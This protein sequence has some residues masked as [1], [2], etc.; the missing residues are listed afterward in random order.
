MCSCRRHCRDANCHSTLMHSLRKATGGT[1]CAARPRTSLAP[2]FVA[3]SLATGGCVVPNTA[4]PGRCCAKKPPPR[5]QGCPWPS[6]SVA[7]DG[8][9]HGR[10]WP[11][12]VLQ[13]CRARSRAP[14]AHERRSLCHQR[15]S[16]Q[17]FAGVTWNLISEQTFSSIPDIETGRIKYR[18]TQRLPIFDPSCIS[19]GVHEGTTFVCRPTS[20]KD[21]PGSVQGRGKTG[22]PCCAAREMI[23]LG[24]HR[25]PRETECDG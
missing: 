20:T 11:W 3:H 16:P 1:M 9:G 12:T 21:S 13:S 25:A 22:A 7:K 17:P 23:P 2:G 10:H 6:L 19:G 24:P 15:T 4:R 8:L 14:R 18:E 5:G